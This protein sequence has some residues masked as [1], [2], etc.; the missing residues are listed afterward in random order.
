MDLLAEMSPLVDTTAPNRTVAKG[1][2]M[3]TVPTVAHARRH[4]DIAAAFY[5]AST[6]REQFVG[7]GLIHDPVWLMMLDSFIAAEDGRS[8]TVEELYR[9]SA[10]AREPARRYVAVMEKRGLLKRLGATGR[11]GTDLIEPSD[12]AIMAVANIID[13]A[14]STSER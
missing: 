7:P 1:T 11:D 3:E 4:R 2:G 13:R 9:A 10:V 8:N 5:E 12:D 6:R 14:E